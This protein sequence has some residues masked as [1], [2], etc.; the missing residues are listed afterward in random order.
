MDED[1]PT[2]ADAVRDH[3]VRAAATRRGSALVNDEEHTL[4]LWVAPGRWGVRSYGTEWG[5]GPE[6]VH[7]WH[8]VPAGGAR[9]VPHRRARDWVHPVV[10]LLWPGMLPVWGGLADRF[11]PIRVIEG[12]H[13]PAQIVLEATTGDRVGGEPLDPGGTLHVDA[14]RWLCTRLEL[15][16]L[17]WTLVDFQDDPGVG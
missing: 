8:I 15:P 7:C 11:R 6:G 12:A 1:V 14:A 5:G 17:T 16:G 10:G 2:L 13:G 3:L 9:E 4:E